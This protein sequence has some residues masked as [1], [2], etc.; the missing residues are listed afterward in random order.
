MRKLLTL[1]LAM[2]IA[3]ASLAFAQQQPESFSVNNA[4]LGTSATTT[5]Q[6]AAVSAAGAVPPTALKYYAYTT[7]TGWTYQYGPSAGAPPTAI[8]ISSWEYAY[9]KNAYANK[10]SYTYIGAGVYEPKTGPITYYNKDGSYAQVS[11]DGS[12]KLFRVQMNGD[13]TTRDQHFLTITAEQAKR[14]ETQFGKVPLEPTEVLLGI[15]G[16]QNYLNVYDFTLIAS[17]L[18]RQGLDIRYATRVPNTKTYYYKSSI[19]DDLL[20]SVVGFNVITTEGTLRK[21]AQGNL[22]VDAQGRPVIDTKKAYSQTTYGSLGPTERIVSGG[23]G[24]D[25]FRYQFGYNVGDTWSYSTG[26]V[27]ANGEAT[28]AK[29]LDGAVIQ[30]QGQRAYQCSDD[31]CVLA[32]T[33]IATNI[34]T[35]NAL[36]N[37]ELDKLNQATKDKVEAAKR[38][39]AEEKKADPSRWELAWRSAEGNLFGVVGQFF[40]LIQE[41]FRGYEQYRGLGAYGSLFI[42][43]EQLAER[44]AK[45]SEQFCKIGLGIDCISAKLCERYTDKH[46]SDST[47]VTVV[48]GQAV[49]A[50]AHVEA[51]RSEPGS[52]KNATGNF[53]QYLYYVTFYASSPDS[54]N[55]VQLQFRYDGGTY[56]WYP[57]PGGEI[58]KGGALSAQ[59]PGA[60]VKYSY[61]K[62][63]QV[64]LIYEHAIDTGLGSERSL[65][66]PVQQTSASASD[67]AVAASSGPTPDSGSSGATSTPG[68]GF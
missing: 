12:M 61:R 44:R 55:H 65:C 56:D 62:Y 13:G 4:A 67:V 29:T 8:T 54:A 45:V 64:C 3:S 1:I 9:A 15:G 23:A 20:V 31:V 37:E 48:R 68:G 21:D 49:R 7:A 51:R 11:A 46:S 42:G 40:G 43:K 38:V 10:E 30:V 47:I 22:V 33:G 25:Y 52:F 6:T 28:V 60:L 26:K 66:V 18:S 58:G 41:F 63:T 19:G 14:Y 2:L 5:Q 39:S 53:T 16:M 57:A 27:N 36:T 17:A 32:D 35:G 50:A 24:G 34:K 59:G